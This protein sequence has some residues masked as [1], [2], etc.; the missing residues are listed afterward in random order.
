MPFDPNKEFE[1]VEQTKPEKKDFNPNEDFEVINETKEPG[2]FEE[3][4]Q[5]E[6][7]ARAVAQGMTLGFSDEIIAGMRSA[8]GDRTFE[9]EL[10]SEQKK[11]N[12]SEEAYP[13]TTIVGELA[14]GAITGG[15]LLK[16][17]GA[18][19]KGAN[20]VGK[21]G[22]IA[23]A[24]ETVG[25]KI[26]KGAKGIVGDIAKDYVL[27]QALESVTGIPGIGSLAAGRRL[28]KSGKIKKETFQKGLEFAMKMIKK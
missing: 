9:E 11:L 1:I 26:P 18:V 17:I 13:I 8:F 27:D 15:A 7:G 4:G 5:F 10:K 6:A 28:L 12:K 14:G 21:A 22:K 23:K 16:G 19:A 25:S 24:A 2:F 20:L 3:G